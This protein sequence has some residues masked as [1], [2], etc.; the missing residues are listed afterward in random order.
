MV[1]KALVSILGLTSMVLVVGCKVG[2]E[3]TRAVADA[4][5]DTYHASLFCD[6]KGNCETGPVVSVVTAGVAKAWRTIE[7]YLW[8]SEQMQD[9][10]EAAA[11]LGYSPTDGTIVQ[12]QGAGVAPKHAMEGQKLKL[13]MEYTI[14]A[15][16]DEHK[17][18][19]VEKWFI[20]KDG[21][22]LVNLDNGERMRERGRW[23]STIAIKL[24]TGIEAGTYVAQA[25]VTVRSKNDQQPVPFYVD[26]E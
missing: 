9:A 6:G 8:D 23:R 14:L 2:S 1:W 10:D 21:K 16:E 19:V 11:A 25:K 13:W 12:V 4:V 18:S 15:P 3:M 26:V 5:S 22:N 24:P 7:P 20:L 17:L